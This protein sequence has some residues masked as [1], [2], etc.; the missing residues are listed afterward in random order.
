M[1]VDG[2]P[3]LVTT[4]RSIKFITTKHTPVQTTSQLKQSLSRVIHLYARAG[5]VVRTILVDGQF[6]PLKNHLFN[7]VVNTTASS[8]HVGEVERC[9]RVIK[10]RA[11]AATA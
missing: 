7:V 9:L 11:R 3:F 10:E 5:F 4:S 1:F 6:E 2:V 8:E